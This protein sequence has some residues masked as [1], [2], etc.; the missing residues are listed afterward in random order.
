MFMVFGR[1]SWC[2][3]SSPLYA[4]ESYLSHRFVE[5]QPMSDQFARRQVQLSW[6][7]HVNNQNAPTWSA[8][9]RHWYWQQQRPAPLGPA[10]TGRSNDSEL[11]GSG[12]GK[13]QTIPSYFRRYLVFLP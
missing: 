12:V 8:T 13:P 11:A 9:W 10:W 1:L 2:I 4:G 5:F 3:I 7:Q 6:Q